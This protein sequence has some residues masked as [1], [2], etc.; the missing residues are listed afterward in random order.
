M[1]ARGLILLDLEVLRF[2]AFVVGSFFCASAEPERL[3]VDEPG[4]IGGTAAKA[5]SI[6]PAVSAVRMDRD[7]ESLPG[8]RLS[9]PDATP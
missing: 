7:M 5:T 6:A 9:R 8:S 3:S 2:K 1:I 4:S